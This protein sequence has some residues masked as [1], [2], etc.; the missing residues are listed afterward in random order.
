MPFIVEDPAA[1][2]QLSSITLNDAA[3]TPVELHQTTKRHIYRAVG[4]I[5]VQPPRQVVRTRPTAHGSINNTRWTDGRL[6][7]LDGRVF[8]PL[9]AS[10]AYAEFRT[11]AGAMLETLDEGSALL[12]WTE[13]GGLSLQALVKLHGEVEPPVE[14]GPNLLAY[15]AQF[16][17]EDPRAYSQTLSTSTGGTL[18]TS[19]GGWAAPET[20][21]ITFSISAGGTTA[22]AN[23]G[24]RPTPPIFRVY[25]AC[26]NPQ[27]LLVGTS[28][29]IALTGS[30]VAG[31]YL[32]IDVAKRTIKMNGTASSLNFLDA[33]ATTWFELPKGTSTIQ[34]LAPTFDTVARCDVL[35]RSAY[36]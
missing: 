22:V 2:R 11:V 20:P 3:G 28:S 1:G 17:A 9:S 16:L 31:A 18:S 24:N 27:I 6:I 10:D 14:V 8:S 15:Q 36:T 29:R 13:H 30:I 34:L 32:E 33:A 4:L 19:P 21:P 26:T 7:V 12:K 25:G 35:Y 5:G 23:V